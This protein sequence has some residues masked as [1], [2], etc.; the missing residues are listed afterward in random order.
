MIPNA[1]GPAL[2][3]SSRYLCAGWRGVP[4]AATIGELAARLCLCRTFGVRW[5]CGSIRGF[6]VKVTLLRIRIVKLNNSAVL[7]SGVECG[8]VRLRCDV[9]ITGQQV[10][11]FFVV[12]S[13]IVPTSYVSTTCRT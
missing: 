3:S 6:L 12:L 9:A 4:K 13:M 1:E 11:F 7:G 8:A 5:P 2:V 10:L